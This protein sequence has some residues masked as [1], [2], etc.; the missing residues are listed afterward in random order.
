LTNPGRL[1]A[2]G[3]AGRGT[4]YH[5]RRANAVEQTGEAVGVEILRQGEVGRKRAVRREESIERGV[6]GWLEQPLRLATTLWKVQLSAAIV[7]EGRAH[8]AKD[9]GVIG[10]AAVGRTVHDENRVAGST[11]RCAQ[12]G[13]LSGVSAHFIHVLPSGFHRIRHYG[14][15]ASGSRRANV[16]RARELLAAILS[17]TAAAVERR[18]RPGTGRGSFVHA[19]AVA[20]ACL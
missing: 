6:V 12:P 10:G 17:R 4:R 19:R 18:T 3:R 1:S 13:R 15:L 16:A 5:D 11:K 20:A 2:A 7:R 8:R 14:L 9:F